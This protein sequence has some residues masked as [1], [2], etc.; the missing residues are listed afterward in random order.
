MAVQNHVTLK[1]YICL[2]SS[3]NSLSQIQ[4]LFLI[5]I[6]NQV[7]VRNAMLAIHYTKRK[8]TLV[9]GRYVNFHFRCKSFKLKYDKSSGLYVHR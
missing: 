7:A 6:Y 1:F 8:N 9:V 2:E 3:L 4:E 5:H